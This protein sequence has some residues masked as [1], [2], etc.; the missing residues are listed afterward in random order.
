MVKVVLLLTTG[1]GFRNV[2]SLPLCSDEAS[3]V[4]AEPLETPEL[5]ATEDDVLELFRF[6]L[7][8]LFVGRFFMSNFFWRS[9]SSRSAVISSWRLWGD[10]VG[11]NKG[12]IHAEQ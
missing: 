8:S 7:L 3:W 5:A 1:S 6:R 10:G 11:G 4:L 12:Y 2:L 9:I